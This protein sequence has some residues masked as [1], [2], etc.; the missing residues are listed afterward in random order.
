MQRLFEEREGNFPI[1]PVPMEKTGPPAS[2]PD[3]SH[4]AVVRPEVQ[5]RSE[6]ILRFQKSERILHW[7]IAVPFMVCFCTG[8]VL[9]FF[10]NLHSPGISRQ[11]LSWL[12]RIAGAVLTFL[13]VLTIVRHWKEY[14]V[15]CYNIKHAWRWTIDDLKWLILMLP[16]GINRRIVLPDQGKFNA[17][18]KLNFLMVLCTYP[19]FIATGL[20][21]WMPERVVLFWIVHVGMALIATPLMLGH[22]YMALINRDTRVGLSGM[23]SGYVDRHWARHHYRNW[24]RENFEED[25]TEE[26]AESRQT[27]QRCRPNPIVVLRFVT[28]LPPRTKKPMGI[29]IL[30]L[31]AAQDPAGRTGE[32]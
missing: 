4:A 12:H 24:Y 6:R 13:P 2:A 18:E 27:L 15:H 30:A 19:L 10:Y 26:K 11:V 17:A 31:P 14:R 1:S 7:S 21:I 3:A 9:M 8:M 29:S 22:I 28:A 20:L 32:N 16:A 5:G 23:L 25:A